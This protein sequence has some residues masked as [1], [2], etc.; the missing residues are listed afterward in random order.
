MKTGQ[1][2]YIKADTDGELITFFD[3]DVPRIGDEV[4]LCGVVQGH[5]LVSRVIWVECH[6]AS[7]QDRHARVILRRMAT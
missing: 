4:S 6:S 5:Y 1:H 3:G 2:R 7:T